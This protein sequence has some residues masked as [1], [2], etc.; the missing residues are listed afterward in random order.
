MTIKKKI[1]DVKSDESPR[2]TLSQLVESNRYRKWAYLLEVYL[3]EDKTYT[4]EEVDKLISG[5]T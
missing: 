2:F 1:K 4:I 3:K 5:L